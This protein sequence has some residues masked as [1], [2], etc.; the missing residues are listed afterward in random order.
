M[1]TCWLQQTLTPGDWPRH[2][3]IDPSGNFMFV[4]QEHANTMEIYKM[5]KE[6]AKIS[7]VSTVSSL[8]KP[9][10]VDFIQ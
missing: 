9:S 8:N 6:D 3:Q 4:T 2:F 7:L 5:N 1:L 10:F